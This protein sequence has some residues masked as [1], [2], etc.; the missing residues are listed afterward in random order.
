MNRHLYYKTKEENYLV[1]HG[2]K[3]QK[4]GVRRYQ[5]PDGTLTEEGKR[6]YGNKQ[7]FE[8]AKKANKYLKDQLVGPEMVDDP[9]L[10]MLG[11]WDAVDLYSK[12]H[13]SEERKNELAELIYEDFYDGHVPTPESDNEKK[14]EKGKKAAQIALMALAVTGTTVGAI[15]IGNGIKASKER[16]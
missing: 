3:G 4:W 9:E 10:V 2:I 5:N 12:T 6:R 14:K 15:A 11:S 16:T 13:L 1:H 8:I 7:N